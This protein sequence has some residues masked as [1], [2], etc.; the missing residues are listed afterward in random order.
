MSQS[1]STD[2]AATTV[3]RQRLLIAVAVLLVGGVLLARLWNAAVGEQLEGGPVALL[4][5]AGAQLQQRPL[6]LSRVDV[7]LESL[8]STGEVKVG[9]MLGAATARQK[10]VLLNFWATWCPPCIEELRTLY[11]LARTVAPHRVQVI[12]VSYDE[13]WGVQDRV[14]R[15]HLGT[16]EPKYIT[17]LRDPAG[18]DG[19]PESMMRLRFGTEKLPETYVL[20]GGKIVARFV[21]PQDWTAPAMGRA[22]IALAEA[23]P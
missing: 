7:P 16:A 4:A 9:P 14:W 21:G 3:V 17:W 23:D 15:E 2:T 8:T 22:L 5:Q 13:D 20:S 10:V 6:D 11:E 1:P 19:E 18:Q 12:A